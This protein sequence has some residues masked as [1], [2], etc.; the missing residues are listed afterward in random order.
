MG[1]GLRP[2]RWLCAVLTMA[3]LALSAAD[4]T[5]SRAATQLHPEAACTDCHAAADGGGLM[6]T[7]EALCGGCHRGGVEASHPSGF[8]P[9]RNL[10]AAFPLDDAGRM[11]CSTCH[12][13]HGKRP[14][15][16]RATHGDRFCLGCHDDA[17]FAAMADGGEALLGFGHLA[18]GPFPDGGGLDPYS[19]RCVDC[20]ID[21]ALTAGVTP[22]GLNSTSH[23]VAR[24]YHSA[25]TSSGYR[26]PSLLADGILL[27][28]GNVG[29]V[30]CHLP[31]SRDHGGQP[32][33][34]AGL[35]AEC[36]EL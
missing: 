23:P 24:D 36:H 11:T 8:V 20:H 19:T 4:P 3:V 9:M 30:S 29:C 12:D 34:R 33:T 2:V 27:P 15:L 14:A 21:Q 6:A 5:T 17:F 18:A 35:C 28:G 10:P 31:Y 16:L 25:A 13:F 26:D 32:Q 22:A 1:R 7:Q